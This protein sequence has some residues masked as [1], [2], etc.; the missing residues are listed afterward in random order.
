MKTFPKI[1]AVVAVAGAAVF[2]SVLPGSAD[3]AA[4]SP[5]L[6]AVRVESPATLEARGAV[7]RVSVTVVCTPGQPA[8]VGIDLVQR[9]GGDIARG[10]DSHYIPSC[11]GNAQTVE[12]IATAYEEPFRKGVTWA[13]GSLNT[14]SYGTIYD[15]REIQIVR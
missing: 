4:Q 10:G 3:V 15:E 13:R 9:S 5:S 6:G 7:V 12:L 14:P 2:A 11:T 1:A 8:Y